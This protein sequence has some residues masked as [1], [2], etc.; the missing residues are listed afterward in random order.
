MDQEALYHRGPGRQPRFV[1]TLK[2]NQAL[3][4]TAQTAVFFLMPSVASVPVS[5]ATCALLSRG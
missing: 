5:I 4:P 1:A 2:P 3:Q